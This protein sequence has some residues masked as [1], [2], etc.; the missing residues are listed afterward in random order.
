MVC[1]FALF[2]FFPFLFFLSYPSFRKSLQAS[3]QHNT[4]VVSLFFFLFPF[5]TVLCRNHGKPKGV[6]SIIRRIDN[7]N[8]TVV[9][10]FSSF[11]FLFFPSFFLLLFSSYR[12]LQK[13]LQAKKN[14]Q[15][16]LVDWQQ[17]YDQFAI[18][19][20][21]VLDYLTELVFCV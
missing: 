3:R 12:S 1:L 21:L 10:P 5:L 16:H 17:Q 14:L 11:L 2:F 13:S 20:M 4:T 6:F 9:P 15:R 7:N 18:C 8:T 19:L